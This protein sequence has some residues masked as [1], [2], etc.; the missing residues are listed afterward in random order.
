MPMSFVT[1]V[2][3]QGDGIPQGSWARHSP[4]HPAYFTV[5][6]DS[7][8]C[9]SQAHLLGWAAPAGVRQTFWSGRRGQLQRSI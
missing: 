5:T 6:A 7:S 3:K 9:R 8:S 2:S 1:L 4:A